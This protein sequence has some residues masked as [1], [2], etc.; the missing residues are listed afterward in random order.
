LDGMDWID[1]PQDR[2][3]WRA[4]VNTV[5]NLLAHRIQKVLEWLHNWRLLK[6]CSAPCVSECTRSGSKS[7]PSKNPTEAVD[8]FL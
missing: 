6:K 7:K 3:H 8:M 5:M 2:D 4:L 1:L